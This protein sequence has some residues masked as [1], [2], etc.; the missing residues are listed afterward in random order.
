MVSSSLARMGYSS[1][2]CFSWWERVFLNNSSNTFGVGQSSPRF[3]HQNVSP[4]LYLN[5]LVLLIASWYN[6]P[7]TPLEV[8]WKVS[9]RCLLPSDFRWPRPRA[10]LSHWWRVSSLEWFSYPIRA[11]LSKSSAIAWTGFKR[12]QMNAFLGKKWK[13]N[14]IERLHQVIGPWK[15]CVLL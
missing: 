3:R 9:W 5:T 10:E 8:G 7:S 2:F 1:S 6:M 15:I 4:I 12:S 13:Y 11:G 14:L